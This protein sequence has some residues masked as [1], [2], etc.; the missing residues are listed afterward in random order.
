M[1]TELQ[2][3]MAR[4]EEA[5]IAYKKAVLAS[6]NGDSTGESIRQAITRFELAGAELR[7]ITGA[8]PRV[9]RPAPAVPR[10]GMPV[11]RIVRSKQPRVGI[12]AP[13]WATRALA[14]ARRL[15]R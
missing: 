4:Y 6:L 7:R 11:A 15:Q 2:R 9:R 5:R 13:A 1:T 12:A 10:A 3:V 8:P 14:A